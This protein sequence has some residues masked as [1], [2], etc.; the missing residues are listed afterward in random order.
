MSQPKVMQFLILFVFIGVVTVGILFL[1]SMQLSSFMNS[2][3]SNRVATTRSSLQV[4]KP[5]L[6]PTATMFDLTL[7]ML[8]TLQPTGTF[9]ISATAVPS[10]QASLLTVA[11]TSSSGRVNTDLVNIRSYP[12]LAGEVVGQARIG[13]QLEIMEKSN[14]GEWLQVCCPLG[15][16][17][18]V[19]QSWISAEFIDIT[20]QPTSAAVVAND[21]PVSTG[22]ADSNSNSSGV[23]ATVTSA[24]ANVRS[25]PD[26]LYATV[27]QLS[28][29]TTLTISGRNATGTWWRICCP[30]G[31]PAESWISAELVTLAIPQDQA[32]AQVPVITVAAAPTPIPTIPV[33]NPTPVLS[34]P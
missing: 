6:L 34:A 10:P 22:N 5:A 15:N 7:D 29:Q 1:L 26:T 31:I 23:S 3:A 8:A 32:M 18:T 14:D 33:N 28:E 19:I 2:T 21:T 25:G 24:L 12:G 13:T 27:G 11:T 17:E 20:F 4:T 9:V 16:S 30:A